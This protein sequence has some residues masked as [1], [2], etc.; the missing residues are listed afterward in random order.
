MN[1]DEFPSDARPDSP[2]DR[3]IDRAVRKMMHVDPRAGL[4]HRVLARLETAPPRYAAFF[5][6]FALA[7][8]VTAMLLLVVFLV[9]RDG[10]GPAPSSASSAARLGVQATASPV[11]PPPEA[12]STASANAT[13]QPPSPARGAPRAAT[14]PATRARSE[15]IRMPQVAN[16]FGSRGTGVTATD[17]SRTAPD[18]VFMSPGAAGEAIRIDPLPATPSTIVQA[19]PGTE[20]VL[21]P[22]A[23]L[24]NIKLD[25]TMTDQREGSTPRARTVTIL[26]QDRE[27]GRLRSDQGQ[28]NA[29]LAVD[30][31]PEV[32]SNGRIRVLLTLDYR[33]QSADGDTG[34]PFN[35]TQSVT[36]IL[37]DGK[38]LVISQSA[39]PAANH[40]AVRVELRATVLR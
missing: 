6:R 36:A 16:V 10:G 19:Q 4:R 29:R 38:P 30:A 18:T 22:A 13:P 21:A 15:I 3:A 39:D 33:P 34:L 9:R 11:A 27:N 26:L 7:A 31:R 23:Q 17:A 1:N 40:A 14:R 32:L 24:V 5:P 37:E 2:L 28:G 25:L 8:G 12:S 20:A 35:L